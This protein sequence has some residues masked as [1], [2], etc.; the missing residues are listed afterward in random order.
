LSDDLDVVVRQIIGRLEVDA[1]GAPSLPQPPRD[2]RF[3]APLSGLYWQVTG[4]PKPLRS[5]S[6]WDAVLNLPD[7]NPSDFRLIR[8]QQEERARRA[9]VRK[10]NRDPRASSCST[11]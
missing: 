5:R 3:E 2:P 8:W 10:C 7:D 1:A 4:G 11:V 6:L 9:R